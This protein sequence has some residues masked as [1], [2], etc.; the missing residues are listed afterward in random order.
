MIRQVSLIL[1]LGA[2]DDLFNLLLF[3]AGT[4]LIV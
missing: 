1:V 2:I 4:S 3:L